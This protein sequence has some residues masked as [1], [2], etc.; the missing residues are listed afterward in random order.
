MKNKKL[1]ETRDMIYL[2]CLLLV[3]DP[4]GFGCI[5]YLSI[6]SWGY[7]QP[8]RCFS[9][10]SHLGPPDVPLFAG[11]RFGL[12]QVKVGLATLVRHYRFTACDRTAVP[13]VLDP[14]SYVTAAKG[15]IWLRVTLRD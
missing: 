10:T 2:P 11:V 9:P 15:G 13:L 4:E 5:R 1:S 7:N 14:R 8:F 12:L 6:R 3:N